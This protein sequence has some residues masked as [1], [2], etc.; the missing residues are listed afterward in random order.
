MTS[1]NHVRQY[2][3]TASRISFSSSKADRFELIL[4]MIIE[5]VIT[6]FTGEE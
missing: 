3:L 1:L 5:S 6:A 4:S 2:A